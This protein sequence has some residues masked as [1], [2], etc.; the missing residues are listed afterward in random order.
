MNLKWTNKADSDLKR[1][2]EFLSTV[3]KPVA[4][5]TIQKIVGQ[6]PI[7]LDNPRLGERLEQFS[8]REVRHFFL[9]SYEIRYELKSEVIYIL[10]LWHTK[11]NR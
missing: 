3:N 11:E 1:L 8:P 7:L 4:I 5:K 6:V 10:R 2:F 9:G